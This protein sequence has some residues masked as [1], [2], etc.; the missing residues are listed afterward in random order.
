ML[1]ALLALL[2]KHW[3]LAAD[4]LLAL[5]VAGS[6]YF[7]GPSIVEVL[8][9]AFLLAHHFIDWARPLLGGAK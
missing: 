6:W 5:I 2:L 3:H 8:L 7:R 9:V 1:A 4:G